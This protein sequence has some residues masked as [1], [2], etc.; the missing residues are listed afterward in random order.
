MT[1]SRSDAPSPYSDDLTDVS[2]V[3]YGFDPDAYGLPSERELAAFAAGYFPEFY[4]ERSAKT[5]D[6]YRP[7]VVPSDSSDAGRVAPR[8]TDV[9][10]GRSLPSIGGTPLE[11]I[12]SDFPALSLQ[13]NG[14]PLVWLDNAA[15]TQRPQQVIDRISHYYSN[16][17]SNVHRGAH[18]L[19]ARS[20]DAFEGARSK[21]AKFIGAPGDK[22]IVFVRGATE[23]LNLVANAYVKPLLQSGDEIILT[24][25]EHHANIVPWQMIAEETG[26]VLRVAPV[27]E[28]G[29][30]I[31]SEYARLFNKRTR[32]VSITHVSNAIGT[33]APVQEMISI[34]HGF[35][36][37]VCVDGAQSI[38][39]MPVNV[40]A[41]D[42]DFFVFSGHKIFGPNGIGALYGKEDVLE[43]A[44]PWQGGGNMIAD[45]TFERTIYHRAP[46]KFEAGTGNIADAVGL[47]AAI[48]YVSAI[49]M[50]NIAL[51]E[52]AL[53]EYG[54]SA[55]GRIPGL[56]MVGRAADRASAIS[57][58]LDCQDNE[59]VGRY[60]N[61]AGI[62]VRTGHHCAQ[63]ILRRLGYEGTVRPSIAF[64]NTYD[65]ID[66]L[67]R[68]VSELAR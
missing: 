25:L 29:Q 46:Q 20:T 34:A 18:T 7:T 35:G 64:Y 37:R 27:D 13:V 66:L 63:P 52:R 40:Y 65:E 3:A 53:L 50:E 45:V 9:E 28:D 31:L 48:D 59:S 62:A 10:P 16:E 4:P 5:G 54:I 68:K 12:R 1:T 8:E 26:A 15:T 6:V 30:I 39:H 32:F 49:G 43:S 19:A 24:Q 57:F 67:A 2:A 22:N 55:L 60:L 47:G 44:R 58:V 61:D 38:S 21:V 36:V 56:T 33:I 17:N 51:Y 41:L 14:K 42:A 11:K 23:G